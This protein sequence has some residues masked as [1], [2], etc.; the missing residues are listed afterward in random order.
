MTKNNLHPLILQPTI[1]NYI[2][3]GRTFEKFADENLSDTEPIAEIWVIYGENKVQNGQLMG[4]SLNDIVHLY[5]SEL[6]GN[7]V[8]SK[9]IEKFPILVKLLDCNLWLSIQVHPNDQQAE[10]LE[11]IDFSGKSEG[12]FVLDAEAGAQLIAGVK[13]DIDKLELEKS[14][15]NGDLIDKLQYHNISKNDSILI[16]AGTIHALGPGSIIYEIQQNSDVTYRVYDWGRPATAGRQLHID[17]SIEVADPKLN[18]HFQ[19]FN[20]DSLTNLIKIFSCDYFELNLIQSNGQT[21]IQNTDRESFHSLTVINGSALVE[22]KNENYSLNQYESILIPA[23]CE[24]YR[25][26]GNFRLLL[27]SLN[28]N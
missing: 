13:P 4:N 9:I 27:G 28:G 17:K 7:R 5:G 3:G 26:S 10:H 1:K 18:V 16:P 25:L 24:T 6:V 19:K 2:W 21:L 8:E 22:Y 12:W 14:I 15:R 20:E 11:G 23:F